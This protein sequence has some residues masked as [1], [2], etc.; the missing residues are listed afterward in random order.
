MRTKLVLSVVLLA[1][2]LVGCR[3]ASSPYQDIGEYFEV[4]RYPHLAAREVLGPKEAVDPKPF[5]SPEEGGY[6]TADTRQ[7][8]DEDFDP[9]A[10]EYSPF[11]T[12]D[13]SQLDGAELYRRDFEYSSFDDD[14]FYP[15][16]VDSP[17][18]DSDDFNELGEEASD[19]EGR[20]ESPLD[21][22]HI[23][24]TQRDPVRTQLEA[25]PQTRPKISP[26][27]AV[28]SSHGKAVH[29]VNLEDDI[30]ANEWVAAPRP[31]RR[32]ILGSIVGAAKSIPKA[33]SGS[34]KKKPPSGDGDSPPS[35]SHNE[36][37]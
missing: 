22:Q 20:E 10:Y 12:D 37:K 31:K 9:K 24:A 4:N 15:L 17:A 29:S 16:T 3:V 30:A 28:P 35:G 25:A 5:A 32:S 18:D 21:E 26:Y 6:D 33:I 7:L 11:D 34:S 19:L 27:T 8:Y 1:G 23:T 36:R 14:D 2:H 13:S